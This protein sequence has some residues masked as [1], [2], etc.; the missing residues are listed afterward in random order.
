MDIAIQ[1]AN[2][3][4]HL[5]DDREALAEALAAGV[6]TVLA[7]GI[8]TRGRASL[9]VSGGSTPKRFFEHLAKADINWS[10]V[11]VVLVDERLVP[12]DHER[13]NAGLVARHLLKDKAADA[14]FVPFVVDG[15]T[16]MDCADSS[17]IAF[18]TVA[19]AFDVVI[20]GMGTDGHT[21]SFF[22][23][24]DTLDQVLDETGD[25]MVL[26]VHAQG[27]GE[28]RLTL[29]LPVLTGARFLALHI[30]GDEKKAVLEKAFAG[31]DPHDMPVRA[32]LNQTKTTVHVFWAP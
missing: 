4:T 13:A 5:Y 16:P 29:T 26:P 32:I 25:R 28:P 20:L 18:E 31:D 15:E 21:A 30:E 17:A 23:G 27:A 7:G 1:A 6:A 9:A 11:A 14:H 3:E 24:G 19:H 2:I 8:A 12:P 22:P 10:A